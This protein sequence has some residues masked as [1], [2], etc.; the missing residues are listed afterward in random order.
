M[1]LKWYR[2]A[3]DDELHEQVFVN[4]GN[5][6]SLMRVE[7]PFKVLTDFGSQFRWSAVRTALCVHWRQP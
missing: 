3:V 1:L 4:G 6:A 7:R 2:M 5:T